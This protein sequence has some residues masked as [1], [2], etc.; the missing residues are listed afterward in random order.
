M[1]QP[2]NTEPERLLFKK[3]L[4]QFCQH[5]IEERIQF[6]RLAMDNAQIAANAEE[7]S[8]AGDKYETSRAMNQ[9]EKDMHAR[10]LLAH[11][12]EL[13]DFLLI[14]T[15]SILSSALPGAV[16]V[17]NGTSYFLSAG[18]GKQQVDGT[19]IL[20]LSPAAPLAIALLHKKADDSIQFNGK[21][22]MISTVF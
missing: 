22:L 3:K 10:Q 4:K 9:I 7:K 21:E 16:V 14:R 13:S 17:C 1:M 18:L 8:S 20:F 15:D 12:K 19:T 2:F 5:T 11:Q 6:A